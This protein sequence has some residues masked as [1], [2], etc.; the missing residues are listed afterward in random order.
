MATPIPEILP[1]YLSLFRPHFTEPSFTFFSSYILSL[2]LSG[3]RKTMSRVAHTCFWVDRHLASWERF[4]SQNRRDT[5]ALFGTLLDTLHA[6]PADGLKI[7]GAYLAVV[8]ILLIAK[9]GHK[10]SGVQFLL[11]LSIHPNK[12]C[13]QKMGFTTITSHCELLKMRRA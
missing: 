11:L 10:M 3:G 6:K 7:H 13:V 2:L 12:G 4:L 9:N 8:D 5:T 1:A